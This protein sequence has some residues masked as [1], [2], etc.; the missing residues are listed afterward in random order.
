MKA[1]RETILGISFLAIVMVIGIFASLR[2][3]TIKLPALTSSSAA[4][5]GALAL[6]LWVRKLG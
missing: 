2:Q 6:K 1:H 4:P 3:Q 5:D